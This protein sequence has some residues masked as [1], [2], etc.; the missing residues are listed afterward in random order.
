MDDTEL[1][2]LCREGDA[3][4]FG[5]LVRRH[6]NH[7]WAVCLQ[8]TWNQHDAEDALQDALTAAWQNLHR[9]RGDARFGTWLQR[10]AANAALA[11]IRRRTPIP[12]TPDEHVELHD[13]APLT[14]ERVVDVDAVRT[15][16]A[17]LSEDFRVAIVLR[18]FADFSYEEI[19]EHQGINV[20]TVR[21]RL[22]RARRQLAAALAPVE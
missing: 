5:E 18:E 16:L 3:A 2:A 21:S 19:A 7:A 20:Q 6:R 17:R 9:F 10:I 15:A 4:A 1:L 12:T 22:N 14:A 8:I 13:L 11:A